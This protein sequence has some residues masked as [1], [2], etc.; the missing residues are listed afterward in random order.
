MKLID[1]HVHSNASDGTMSPTELVKYADSKGLKAIALTDHDTTAGI[2]EAV[3]AS[4]DSNVTVIPGIEL[5]ADYHGTD[6]HILGLNLDLSS[7]EFQKEIAIFQESRQRRND[8]MIKKLQENGVDITLEKMKLLYG[9]ASMTRAHYARY[10]T[11]NGYTKDFKE[12]FDHYIGKGKPCYVPRETI[13]PETAIRFIQKGKGKPV[14]AHPLLYRFSHEELETLLSNL[15]DLGLEGLET[16]YSTHSME[17]ERYLMKLALKYGLFITGGSDFHGSNKPDI[18]LGCGK[19]N[20]Q[21]PYSL[22]YPVLAENS[23]TIVTFYPTSDKTP[24]GIVQF[25][26]GMNEYKERY[27]HIMSYLSDAGYICVLNDHRGHGENISSLDD[28]GYM[29]DNGADVLVDDLHQITLAMQDSY[30]ELPYYLFGHSMGSLVVR[31]YLKKYDTELNGLI[32]CGCPGPNSASGFGIMLTKLLALLHGDRYRSRFM[33]QLVLGSF[34]K[35]FRKGSGKSGWIST[36]TEIVK[37]YAKDPKCNFIFTLNG[38]RTLFELMQSVYTKKGWKVRK[39]ELPIWFISGSDDPCM[40]N[41]KKFD[42]AVQFLKDVGYQNVTSKLYPGMRH[43][44]L[45]EIDQQKVF[46][47][48]LTKLNQW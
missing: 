22:L 43:E 35:K 29:G 4:M 13:T 38:Y 30:P 42:E 6:I 46:Q 45:N 21:I 19:G 25:A 44:I 37:K 11:E 27:H 1:L 15:K 17:D 20:L 36:N 2:E 14:L 48:I 34:Q 41:H 26:H 33:N 24:S 39:M 8:I 47:D 3:Q 12:A 32:V 28:L 5:A 9:N 23:K 18:D 40:I 10:L 16:V 7:P 31:A